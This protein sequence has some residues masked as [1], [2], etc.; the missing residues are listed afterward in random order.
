MRLSTLCHLLLLQDFKTLPLLLLLLGT[1]LLLLLLLP[2]L[3]HHALKCIQLPPLGCQL[4]E[5][6]GRP[7]QV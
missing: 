2:A 3:Q 7:D 5:A 1:L 4:V 6:L